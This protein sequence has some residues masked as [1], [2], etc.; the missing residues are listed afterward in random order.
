M[1]LYVENSF[2]CNRI[3]F[4]FLCQYAENKSFCEDFTEGKYSYPVIHAIQTYPEDLVIR[5]EF[6]YR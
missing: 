3:L 2:G 5:S 6:L 1:L 4:L